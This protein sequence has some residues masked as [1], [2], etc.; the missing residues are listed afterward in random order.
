MPI[1][2][3]LAIPIGYLLGSIPSAYIIGR[4]VGKI[5]LRTEGDGRVSAAA[6]KKRLG[7]VPFLIVVVMDVCKGI[8]AVV[9]AKLLVDSL[10]VHDLPLEPLLI[11]LATGFVAVVGH[12]WSP[13]IRFQGGLGATVIYGVL[14]GAFLW[15]QELI[16]LVVG[17]ITVVITR[18]SGFSTGVIIGVLV[19]I[20][21]VQKMIWSPGMSPIVVAYPVILILLMVAKRFQVRKTSGAAPQGLFQSWKDNS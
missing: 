1:Y 10:T 9:F 17:G 5:D 11:V 4:L 19:I 8:L 6:V 18:K 16:A 3:F 20:L 21:L 14:C 15:P 7:V 12:S 13:F 2:S